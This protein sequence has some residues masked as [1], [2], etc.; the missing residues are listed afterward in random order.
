MAL[1]KCKECGKEISTTAD[2]CP[3]C[4]ASTGSHKGLG[5]LLFVCISIL[6]IFWYKGHSP[7]EVLSTVEDYVS[8]LANSKRETQPAD[9]RSSSNRG[10]LHGRVFIATQGV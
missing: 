1:T 5:C 3:S 2:K 7:S 6:A 4:G 8:S 9:S 10:Q